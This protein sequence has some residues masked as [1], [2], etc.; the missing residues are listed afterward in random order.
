MPIEITAF[1]CCHIGC[2]RTYRHKNS[3]ARHE[4]NCGY[5]AKFK[6]CKSC[7]NFI[8][9]YEDGSLFYSCNIGHVADTE[10]ADHTERTGVY[11]TGGCPAWQQKG[12]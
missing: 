6:R 10:I 3:C 8:K 5:N 4:K 1:E 7:Q 2:I 11:Y 12:E 9:Y